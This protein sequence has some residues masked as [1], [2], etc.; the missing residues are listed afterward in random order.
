[1]KTVDKPEGPKLLVFIDDSIKVLLTVIYI[2]DNTNVSQHN[3]MGVLK[4]N[5]LDYVSTINFS[6]VRY[7]LNPSPV[8]LDMCGLQH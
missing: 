5:V 3:G 8:C 6:Q 4:F 1:M 2:Y 7:L